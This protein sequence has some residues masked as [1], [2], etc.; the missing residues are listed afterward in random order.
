MA[1][2]LKVKKLY[3]DIFTKD[4][5]TYYKTHIIEFVYDIIF[6]GGTEYF[7]S[8]Q[9]VEFLLAIQNGRRVAAKSGKGIGKS[10]SVAFA[11]LWFLCCFDNP[12]IC[13]SAPSL[14]T[15]SSALWPEIA[16]WLNRTELK[17]IFTQTATKLFLT[18]LP[19]T[20]YAEPRTATKSENLQGLH[21]ENMLLIIDE[22]SAIEQT[23]FDAFNTTLTGKN[24]KF[25]LIGNPTRVS[26]PFFDC[27]NRFS[28]K[29]KTMTFNAE[30]SP[31]VKAE[32]IE[33]FREKYGIHH[34]LYKVSVLGEFPSGSPESFL[35][36]SDVNG[37]IDRRNSVLKSK[38]IE[39]GLDVAR[40]GDDSTVL[41]WREGYYVHKPK[42][43]AKNTIP[44]AAELVLKTVEEIRAR[45]GHIGRIRVKVDSVGLGSGV[46]DILNMDRTHNIEVVE[47]SN[48]G[49]GNEHYHNETSMG[50]GHLRDIIDKIGLPDDET[51]KEELSSRKWKPSPTGKV[52]IQP[53]SEFKK[54]YKASPDRADALILCFFNKANEKSL[55]KNFDILDPTLVKSN[56]NYT[57]E[58]KF[59]SVFYSRDTTAYVVY[60]SWD[61]YRLYIYDEFINNDAMVQTAANI[62]SHGGMKKIVG[63]DSMFSMKGDDLASKF[64]KYGVNIVEDFGFN[65]LASIEM[66]NS[67]IAKRQIVFKNTCS[68]IIQQLQDWKMS[69]NRLEMEDL[70]GLCYAL[71]HLISDIKVKMQASVPLVINSD[72]SVTN[73]KISHWMLF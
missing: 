20:W 50:W 10:T 67:M 64:R 19:Q 38:E 22:A 4:M 36:L 24:N 40:F 14:Q 25:I 37:A 16:L 52:M 23:I 15:L 18:E 28:D 8:D 72:V 43:L 68:A 54:E 6:E 51:L 1:R 32:H 48:G 31:F 42:I 17:H 71:L 3:R 49:K 29:W 58:H 2:Q 5:I 7:L 21:A 44:E 30:E 62:S 26:G 27:F 33:Y 55:V 53:K 61:G 56:I 70:Y 66:L 47:C 57:G 34:D 59:C 41:F 39:I 60:G 12:R 11:I 69:S 46:C 73:D 35:K 45:T 65:E 63:N 9:Q 13:A